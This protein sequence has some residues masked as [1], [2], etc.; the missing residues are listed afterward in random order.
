MRKAK[1][2]SGQTRT[3][4]VRKLRRALPRCAAMCASAGQVR[5]PAAPA[6]GRWERGGGR[7]RC[8][9]PGRG[10]WPVRRGAKP[11]CLGPSASTA[12]T[13]SSAAG[14]VALAL[15][16][17]YPPHLNKPANAG[18]CLPTALCS[19]T[20]QPTRSPR[21]HR[22]QTRPGSSPPP[23]ALAPG[24]PRPSAPPRPSSAWHGT[25]R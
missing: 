2:R 12:S 15:C 6:G 22:P 21:R 8:R 13:T 11:K 3:L 19:K 9:R 16:R 18:P 1:K 14:A 4:A 24:A 25:C 23:P 20:H 5:N 10:R 17:L 7:G